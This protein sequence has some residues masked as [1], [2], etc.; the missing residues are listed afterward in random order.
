MPPSEKIPYT[1]PSIPGSVKEEFAKRFPYIDITDDELK[2]AEDLAR[3][4]IG[5]ASLVERLKEIERI[6]RGTDGRREN[7]AEHSYMVAL[8]TLEAARVLGLEVDTTKILAYS[9]CHDLLEAE[10]GDTNTFSLTPEQQAEKAAREEAALEK[11]L[12]EL[13]EEASRYL[14][15]YEKGEDFEARFVKAIDKLAPTAVNEASGNMDVILEDLNVYTPDDLAVAHG[16]LNELYFKRFGEFPAVIAAHGLQCLILEQRMRDSVDAVP[17][18]EL[19]RS[20]TET[21]R[22]FLVDTDSLLEH[23]DLES[24]D[25]KRRQIKQFYVAKNDDGSETRIRSINNSIF[26][27]TKKSAGTIQREEDTILLDHMTPKVFEVSFEEKGIGHI[28]EK[29]RYIIPNEDGRSIE[30]D[31]YGGN[32][33]GLVT[34]EIE[35]KGRDA[36]IKAQAW[37][38]SKPWLQKEV[39]E[40]GRFKNK[41]LSLLGGIQD[42]LSDKN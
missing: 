14:E 30:I 12:T 22:K 9:L 38:P 36:L 6:P 17:K 24:P 11:M 13:P 37:Q 15:A 4:T 8:S 33:E 34:A 21:E 16:T 26:Q 42:L 28:I 39:T 3:S 20:L 23:V 5:V 25:I 31:V 19:Q 35:F 40:D 32:L 7:L 18:S 27:Q 29:T 41:N 1:G 2:Q 10:T